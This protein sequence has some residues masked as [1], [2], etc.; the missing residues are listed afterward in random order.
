M[1]VLTPRKSVWAVGVVAALVLAACGND[2][3]AETEAPEE[4]TEAEDGEAAAPEIDLETVTVCT[5]APYEPFEF[6]EGGEFTGFDMDLLR[7]M[8][9]RLGAEMEV[10][11]QPF[12]GIWL[13]PQAGTCDMVASAMTITPDRAEQALF[14]DPYLTVDQSLMVLDENADQFATLDD[15]AGGTIG[16][17]TGTTG[18]EYANE[19]APEGADIR[20]FDEAGAMF[21]ALE[22]GDIDAI[23]QDFP[24]NAFRAEQEEQ[25][26]VTDTFPTGEEYGFATSQD[27]TELMDAINAALAEVREDGTYDEIH[28]EWF[29][30]PASES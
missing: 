17:Q 10:T 11:V 27:N 15:L 19:N 3:D 8:L 20:S 28:A 22:S 12:D 1:R 25:F 24:V 23:L 21:L 6:E 16:V 9:D 14:S 29:G 18:E 7:E 5:D 13:A 4:D 30:E 26:E 2:D